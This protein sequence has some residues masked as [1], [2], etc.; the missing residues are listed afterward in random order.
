M[1][2]N[3]R[4][5]PARVAPEFLYP[6]L[7]QEIAEHPGHYHLV[8]DA[9]GII[10][11]A[12]VIVNLVASGPT[13]RSATGSI[14][15]IFQDPL[16][17]DR[18]TL[19]IS[20]ALIDPVCNQLDGESNADEPQENPLFPTGDGV[21]GGDFVARFTVDSRP[22]LGRLGGRQCLG[23]YQWQ[24]HL[25]SDEPG[26][27]QP[28]H[29]LPD[30]LHQRRRVCRQ[31]CGRVRWH[32]R[33]LRQAGRVRAWSD[34]QWRWLIDTDNDGV[35]NIEQVDPLNINGLPVAG[36]FDGNT[37][38]GDEVGVFTGSVWYFDTNHDFQLDT[39]LD[40]TMRG[41][42]DRRRLRRRR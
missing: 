4:D 27:H 36:E 9:N 1:T 8:G 33:W 2:I 6:A 18:F 23:R 25:R 42:P 5:L 11:I 26:L 3:V 35:A 10:P 24:L 22:E 31:L 28:R 14:Q 12:D 13:A 16:P 20:D 39:S 17:D 34:G 29:H 15:L 30:G 38:N 37:A 7:V 32:R 40:T 21:P 41:L 19:T